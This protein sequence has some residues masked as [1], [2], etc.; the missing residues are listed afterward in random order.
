MSHSDTEE[1]KAEAA[2][3]HA[4]KLIERGR[5]ATADGR[6]SDLRPV[7]PAIAALCTIIRDMPVD[8]ARSWVERLNVLL[9]EVHALG[10]EVAARE[11]IE[12]EAAARG[13]E[14]ASG[15]EQTPGNGGGGR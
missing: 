10:A 12:A 14:P 11:A 13:E 3:R 4:A 15:E 8:M 7:Q 2:Y 9:R 5:R 1:A 6:K